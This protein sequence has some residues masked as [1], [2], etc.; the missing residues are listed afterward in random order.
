MTRLVVCA[1]M[2]TL[3]TEAA[4]IAAD[5]FVWEQQVL[6]NDTNN[7]FFTS[8][9]DNELRY[10]GSVASGSASQTTVT[11]SN[12]KLVGTGPLAEGGNGIPLGVE[13]R[14]NVEFNVTATG[15]G[16]LVDGGNG[17]LGVSTSPEPANNS[18]LNGLAPDGVTPLGD[19]LH[20]GTIS[21]TPTVFDPIGLLDGSAT[22]TDPLW[23]VLRSSTHAA[24]DETKTS[25][26]FDLT[27]DVH[28]FSGGQI[29]NNFNDGQ[30]DP[31]PS[32]F[33][34]TT[35]GDWRLKGIG[36]NVAVNYAV[37]A[38]PNRRS[39][40]FKNFS[41][42]Q[43]SDDGLTVT[44]TP[45]GLNAV[46]DS[47]ADGVGVNS[48]ADDFLPDGITPASSGQQRR[49]DGGLANPES[50]QIVFDQDVSLESLIMF[51]MNVDDGNEA[52]VLKYVSGGS[53]PFENGLSGYSS[54]YTIGADSI[55]FLTTTGTQDPF[56]VLFG[57]NG[58]QALEIEAGTILSIT[59]NPANNGGVL[60][61]GIV[62]SVID[63]SPVDA[64]FDDDEDVDGNDFLIWQ[65]GVGATG[66][67]NADGDATGEGNVDGEDLAAWEGAFGTATVN[68]ASVPEPGSLA[69]AAV[70]VAAGSCLGAR[71]SGRRRGQGGADC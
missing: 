34:T 27:A 39:F 6:R 69:L 30:F 17:G 51:S 40:N 35:A 13:V 44:L 8:A 25:S 43:L 26:N 11:G 64:D 66:A 60:L 41:G 37:A 55:T 59:G 67:S 24:P 21:V 47:N 16:T 2:V 71:R 45:V 58:Q 62:A 46:F 54:D 23:H 3:T 31:L 61:G 38:A 57:K 20:F 52:V 1:L 4:H 49:I 28:T 63:D 19:Q 7:P 9:L 15:G 68:S 65:R 22:I 32:V 5:T 48:D 18:L 53:N 36:Y 29:A 56:P 50:L 12:L 14:M 42:N 10:S 70:G 33:V